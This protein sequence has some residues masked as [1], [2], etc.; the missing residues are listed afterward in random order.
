MNHVPH[1]PTDAEKPGQPV[2]RDPYTPPEKITA[3]A[4][5]IR[6]RLE[7]VRRASEEQKAIESPLVDLPIPDELHFEGRVRSFRELLEEIGRIEDLV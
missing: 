6:L 4:R 7:E 2:G 3:W 5:A 1:R